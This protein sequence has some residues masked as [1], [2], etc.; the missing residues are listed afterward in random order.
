MHYSDILAKFLMMFPMYQE[1]ICQWQPREKNT[2][3]V[4][5]SNR[6]TLDFTYHNDTEWTLTAVNP[7]NRRI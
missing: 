2:I 5:T 6:L 1:T 4:T 7:R 3:R